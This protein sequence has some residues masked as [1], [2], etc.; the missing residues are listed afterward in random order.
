MTDTA[1]FWQFRSN[2]VGTWHNDFHFQ[3]WMAE[4]AEAADHRLH[5]EVTTQA[6]PCS[7]H[8]LDGEL[9][10][11]FYLAHYCVFNASDVYRQDGSDRKGLYARTYAIQTHVVDDAGHPLPYERAS[12]VSN[13]PENSQGVTTYT[14]S[15]SASLDGNVG[16]FG[17]QPTAGVSGG[18]S[19]GTSKSFAMADVTIV[20]D[21]NYE[22]DV[23]AS[24]W[25]FEFKRP[26]IDQGVFSSELSPPAALAHAT[27]EPVLYEAWSLPEP[28]GERFTLR[29][30]V[31]VGLEYSTL[32][33]G[34]VL[35]HQ[36]QGYG[37][38]ATHLL[39]VPYPPPPSRG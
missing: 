2:T 1:D 34:L 32:D 28:Y 25:T 11:L 21:S 36:W 16:M 4:H 26:D 39:D 35:R 22:N 18:V 20:N 10:Y 3:R 19:F 14:S 7:T 9:R 23:N 13:S 15:M 12:M 30:T 5:L 31:D 37:S 6:F 24:R 17:D 27:F 33:R 8:T 29:M 38:Q